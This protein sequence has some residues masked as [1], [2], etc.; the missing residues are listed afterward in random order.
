MTSTREGKQVVLGTQAEGADQ[1]GR[2]GLAVVGDR[3]QRMLLEAVGTMTVCFAALELSLHGLVRTI[4]DWRNE[5][6]HVVTRG[7]GFG[8]L[9]GLAE[10]LVKEGLP[11]DRGGRERIRK[12]LPRLKEVSKRRNAVTHAVVVNFGDEHA[13]TRVRDAARDLVA[14]ELRPKRVSL[15][16]VEEVA[17]RCDELFNEVQA[18][19]WEIRDAGE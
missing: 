1:Q 10:A 18:V 3:E 19:S 6:V 15:S 8:E 13:L 5:A 14:E 9:V 4:I 17:I 11:A 2:R 16:E 12:L 7:M